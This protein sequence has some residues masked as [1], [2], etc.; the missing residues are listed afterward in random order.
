MLPQR[1]GD[2]ARK[3]ILRNAD[4]GPAALGNLLAM[5]RLMA[6]AAM[7][8]VVACSSSTAA[9]TGPAD[10][11]VTSSDLP[12]NLSQCDGSGDID[13]FLNA[14]KT[15]DPTTYKSTQTEWDDAKAHGATGA[16]VVFFADSKD[17][18]SSIQNSG[19]NDLGSATYP[20]V[21]NFVIKFKDETT[22]SDGYMNQSIFGFSESTLS[23]TGGSGVVKGVDTGLTKNAVTLTVA[24]GN[25]SFYFAVWQNK[26]FM[27]I[28]GVLNVDVGQSKK[29]ATTVNGRIK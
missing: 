28:L 18:C 7:L 21:I 19:N 13:T 10:V 24:I 26:A 6:A 22:A 27:V 2:P 3:R 9:L 1:R 4:E 5:R 16:Q 23:S 29:I 12:K 17:H 8:F 20:L 15:K 11:A 25:Q 14:I